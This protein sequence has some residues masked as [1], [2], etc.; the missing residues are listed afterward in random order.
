MHAVRADAIEASGVNNLNVVAA[1]V[2][3]KTISAM[4]NPRV[5]NDYT[6]H[7]CVFSSVGVGVVGNVEELIEI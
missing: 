1:L 5:G 6:A 2:E 3:S 7:F 4:L